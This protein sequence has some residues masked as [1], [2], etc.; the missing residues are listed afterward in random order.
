MS[1]GERGASRVSLRAPN[2]E[3]GGTDGPT[4]LILADL[5]EA[6]E[7]FRRAFQSAPIG[8]A[9]VDPEGRYV[10]VNTALCELLGYEERGLL[11]QDF[12]SLSHPDE[13]ERDSRSFGRMLRGEISSH[14][15][16]KRYRHAEGQYVWVQVNASGICDSKN[17]PLDFIFQFQ[18]IS[19]RKSAAEQLERYAEYLSRL[20][21]QDPLTGLRNYRELHTALDRELER[22]Q[23]HDHEFSIVLIDVDGFRRINEERGLALGDDVLRQV[24]MAVEGVRRASDIATRIG[25]D[26][27][28]LLLP[29]TGAAGAKASSERARKAVEA[30]DAGVSVSTGTAS[31]P[32]DGDTKALLLLHAELN[33][34]AARPGGSIPWELSDP[35]ARTSPPEEGRPE[36]SAKSIERV[37]QMARAQ[38][39]MDVAYLA[40]FEDGNQVYR[41]ISGDGDPFAARE[42]GGIPLSETFCRRMVDGQLGNIVPDA[43][44]EPMV[45]DLGVM[46][47]SDLGAYIG[48]PLRLSDGRLYGTL[49]CIDHESKS[50]L[51]EREVR[52]MEFLGGLIVDQL[53]YREL[54]ARDRRAQ[55]E[56]TGIHALVNA[57][58]ARDHYTG[59]H[60]RTVVRLATA[61]ARELGLSAEETLEVEH[62]AVLHDI[63]KVGIPD[64]VLQKV[65]SLNTGEAELMREHPAVG[66]RIVARTTS[67]AHL[68]PAIRAEH[69]RW[70]GGGYPE[71]LRGLDIPIASRITF[72]CDAYH[73]MTSDRPYRAAM[74]PSEAR[75]ELEGNAGAQFDPDVVSALLRVIDSMPAEPEPRPEEGLRRRKA[76]RQ[77]DRAAMEMGSVRRVCR[78]CGAH[79]PGPSSD[80]GGGGICGNCGANDLAVVKL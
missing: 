71:G 25:G 9:I 60:S 21:L 54:E 33:L 19:E 15:T 62:V 41:T 1:T 31:W 80:R 34:H 43:R 24:A 55:I 23:R 49:C 18:D 11:G 13:V 27:F 77:G 75:A 39:E 63:G 8:M 64:S 14:S 47:D 74:D 66:A 52:L 44:A 28:A 16:E 69:E 35:L 3:G 17:R 37:L 51:G 22:S 57:L 20:A 45:A 30:L 7:R 56:V 4:Q 79:G 29:E 6:Q 50:S 10:E 36:G 26:E 65:G 48:V 59:E 5:H 76:D 68:A 53:E 2:G 46:Q 72:A 78:A 61:V 58:E 73:A 42:G 38:L 67:L 32:V 12:A 70:D 40:E